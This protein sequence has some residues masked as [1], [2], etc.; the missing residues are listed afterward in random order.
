MQCYQHLAATIAVSHSLESLLGVRHK[1]P[2]SV[3]ADWMEENR[4]EVEDLL[5]ATTDDIK[6]QIEPLLR[7]SEPLLQRAA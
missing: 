2:L 5:F 6:A 7:Q 1:L 3:I 4:I